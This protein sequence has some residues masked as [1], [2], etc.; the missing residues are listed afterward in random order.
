MSKPAPLSGAVTSAT[1]TAARW[2]HEPWTWLVFGLPA[3]AVIGS[4]V[5]LAIAI[6]TSD[7]L[8]VDDY[9]KEGLQINKVIKR[10]EQAARLGL[11]FSASVGRDGRLDLHLTAAPGYTYPPGLTVQ[12]H[13]AT[14]N[15]TDRQTELRLVEDGHYQGE[16]KGMEPGPWYVDLSTAEWRVVHRV[17]IG[18]DGASLR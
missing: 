8:V 1:A 16:A 12:L 7:T 17:M 9:Y 2:H 18:G 3:A 15:G 4:F 11:D 10:E 6:R 5:T 13:H 14:G